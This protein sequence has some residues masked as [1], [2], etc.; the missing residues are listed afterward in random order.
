MYKQ[1]LMHLHHCKVFV[2]L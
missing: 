2:M 1:T